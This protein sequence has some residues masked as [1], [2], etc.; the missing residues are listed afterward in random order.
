M[1]P[2]QSRASGRRKWDHIA[3]EYIAVFL[4]PLNN[5]GYGRLGL[6]GIIQTWASIASLDTSSVILHHMCF[7]FEQVFVEGL[8]GSGL[9]SSLILHE[10]NKAPA[11]R[12]HPIPCTIIIQLA[13]MDDLSIP[14]KRPVG[15]TVTNA[16]LGRPVQEIE[17]GNI[18]M[19]CHSR[20]SNDRDRLSY[21][22]DSIGNLPALYDRYGG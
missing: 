2:S 13:G 15:F 16:C 11:C 8:Q 6:R 21:G 18:D 5:L 17:I 22:T 9:S 12:S 14:G 3:V 7:V 1:N 19:K 4:I 20:T 10:R